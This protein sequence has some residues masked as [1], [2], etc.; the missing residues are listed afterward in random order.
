MFRFEKVFQN[1]DNVYIV[2]S[3]I[4]KSFLILLTTHIFVIL[5]DNSIYE[6]GDYNTFRES[7]FFFYAVYLTVFY[8]IISFFLKNKKEYQKN[9]ISFL[10][11]DIFNIS[12]SVIFT[13]ALIFILSVDFILDIKFFYLMTIHL[14]VLI[15]MKF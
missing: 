14:I 5:F 1:D 13:L 9:F 12:I 15:F 3:N 4:I 6:L 11:E 8:L 10:K 2:F 7:N